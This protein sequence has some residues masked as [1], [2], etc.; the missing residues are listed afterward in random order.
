MSGKET[1][2][3]GP[4]ILRILSMYLICVLHVGGGFGGMAHTSDLTTKCGVLA[5]VSS[6]IVAVN[7]FMMITGYIGITHHWSWKGYFKVWMQVAFYSI[8][9]ILFAW[10]WFGKLPSA[11]VF[12]SLLFPIPLASGYWYF[13]AY[14]AAFFLFL[15]ANKL[16]ISLSK[17][18]FKRLLVILLIS[19]CIFGMWHKLVWKGFNCVWMLIMYALGAYIRLHLKRLCG[20]FTLGGYFL[21]SALVTIIAALQ[22]YAS[23][24]Y[25]ISLGVSVIEYTALPVVAASFFLFVFFVQRSVKGERICR[26]LRFAAP[27][28]FG[29]YLI[30]LHPLLEIIF[31]QM[32][33]S[34]GEW[35]HYALW[36]TPVV[37]ALIYII[38]SAIDWCR[39]LLFKGAALLWKY[40]FLSAEKQI[41]SI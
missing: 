4:D 33:D 24:E 18:E 17:D 40:F 21:V 34:I 8:A 37:A 7:L 15:Y 11:S 41:P 10:W 35:N 30:H 23:K 6:A 26:F 36:H 20:W 2:L 38:C 31:R 16:L 32:V 3:Y 13:T 22:M 27:L 19:V 29:V 5:F 28:T 12:Q 25:G 1:H 14:T 9:G 39:F